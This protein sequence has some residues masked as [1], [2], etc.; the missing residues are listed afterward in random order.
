MQ[1]FTIFLN[2]D[3]YNMACLN[4]QNSWNYILLQNIPKFTL[5]LESPQ[6]LIAFGKNKQQ[7]YQ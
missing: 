2:T 3:I 6:T 1:I 7:V 4:V 5:I